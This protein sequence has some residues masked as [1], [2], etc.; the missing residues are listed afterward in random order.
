MSIAH[1]LSCDV[2]AAILAEG[3]AGRPGPAAGG[4]LTDVVLEVHTTLRRLTREARR[5]RL[6]SQFF[7]ASDPAPAESSSAASGRR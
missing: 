5:G 4:A 3:D 2:A 1:E 7:P 6:N